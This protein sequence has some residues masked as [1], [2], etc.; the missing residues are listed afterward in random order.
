M[1]LSRYFHLDPIQFKFVGKGHTLKLIKGRRQ[2]GKR[3]LDN[4]I[5]TVNVY[6]AG[7]L[8]RI[9]L[10][11]DRTTM[12]HQLT[13]LC[14]C[15]IILVRPMHSMNTHSVLGGQPT[16]RP[17]QPIRAVSPL[18]GCCRPHSPSPLVII[19]QFTVTRKTEG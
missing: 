4:V 14:I 5:R 16:L 10:K 13:F 3:A 19:T 6:T 1:T 7:G 9:T 15:N 8:W 17:S 11:Y 18:E 12:L 2:R